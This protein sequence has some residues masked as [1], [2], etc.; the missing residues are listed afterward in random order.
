[1][2][3]RQ[4]NMICHKRIK[5]KRNCRDRFFRNKSGNRNI[6]IIMHLGIDFVQVSW[7]L[8]DNE[9]NSR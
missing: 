7:L 9:I 5:R 2:A 3:N 6:E 8:I 4:Q 1:M